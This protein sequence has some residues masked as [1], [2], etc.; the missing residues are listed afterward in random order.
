MAEAIE[1]S[2]TVGPRAV[3]RSSMNELGMH[4]FMSVSRLEND[5]HG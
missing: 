2:W 4:N 1:V 3:S 5:N